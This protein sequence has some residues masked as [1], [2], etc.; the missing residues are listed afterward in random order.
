MIQPMSFFFLIENGY[1]LLTASFFNSVSRHKIKFDLLYVCKS[2]IMVITMSLRVL[3]LAGI[4][5]EHRSEEFW[6]GLLSFHQSV[7]IAFPDQTSH[8]FLVKLVLLRIDVLCRLF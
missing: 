1:N 4:L 5:S 6:V 7:E 8:H 3:L 2:A